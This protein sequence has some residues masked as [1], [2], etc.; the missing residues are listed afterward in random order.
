MV[1]LLPDPMQL[2]WLDL[3]C[4][5]LTSIE[6][7]LLKFTNLQ[8]LYLHGNQ[9]NRL[10]D[11]LTLSKLPKLQKATLHGNPISEKPQYKMWV[12]AH[13]PNLKNLDFSGVTKLERDKV[14]QWYKGYLKQQ[15]ARAK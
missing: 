7:D 4:N 15:E 9:I 1:H 3:S 10:H 8:V 6:P 13:L 5:Q 11:V 12:L 14:D 2:T